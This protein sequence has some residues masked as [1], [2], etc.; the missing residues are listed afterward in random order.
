MEEAH[1]PDPGRLKEL[2]V[3]DAEVMVRHNPSPGRKTDWTLTLVK[4]G[5]VWVSVNSTLPNTFVRNLLL[6]N[7]LPGFTEYSE[8]NAEVTHENSRFDFLLRNGKTTY[9]M[10]VKSVTLV[11]QGVGLF[12]DAPT[13]RGTRH[14][15]HL[16]EM[17]SGDVRTGVLFIVQRP[18]AELFAPNWIT[19][20]EFAESL[21]KGHAA[22][23]EITVFTTQVEPTGISLGERIDYDLEHTYPLP[24]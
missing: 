19:D 21:A 5:G 16:T 10:E 11:H 12:P 4:K 15:R 20:P 3:P 18:D 24:D 13:T 17:L 8:I 1:V 22:G 9:W 7:R 6:Q 14:V 23:L 2:L